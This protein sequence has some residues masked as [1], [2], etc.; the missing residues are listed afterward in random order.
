MSKF[1]VE[2]LEGNH[3]SAWIECDCGN[4]ETQMYHDSKSRLAAYCDKCD[5]RYHIGNIDDHTI[6]YKTKQ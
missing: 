6:I 3:F 1:H 4:M 2:F 5:S